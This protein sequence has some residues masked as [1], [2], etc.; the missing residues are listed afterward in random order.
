MKELN[1]HFDFRYPKGARIQADFTRPASEFSITALFGPSGCGKTTVLRCLAG[2]EHPQQGM[3]RFEGDIWFDRK[4]GIHRSPSERNVGLLFQ[5]YALFPHLTVKQNISYG[6][7]RK[8][9]DERRR[10]VHELLERFGLH[11]MDDRYPLQ[12]SGGQ[13]QRVAL[14]RTLAR[15]PRLL[16][17]DE[18]L[19]AL[20][21]MLRYQ[22]RTEL[23]QLLS[24]FAI[25]TFLVTHDWQEVMFLAD[26]LIVMN[27]GQILQCGPVQDVI[28]RPA[29]ESVARLV[30]MEALHKGH[31][32]HRSSTTT[33]VAVGRVQ[34]QSMPNSLIDDNVLVRIRAEDV[35]IELANRELAN[36]PNCIPATIRQIAADG[37]LSRLDLDCGF[38]L[39]AL[40]PRWALNSLKIEI[41]KEIYIHI[42]QEAVHLIP[43]LGPEPADPRTVNA[44]SLQLNHWS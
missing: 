35:E 20:D 24:D 16:L 26:H 39:S 17:L 40:L 37:G 3:I 32:I 18:P 34:L 10:V 9:A 36:L 22:M 14:A 6:L 4:R 44:S 15:Q 21:S 5:D 19:S 41:G 30:G 42:A 23:H 28:C 25:P 1:A 11:G 43:L 27:E 29:N 12:L 13:Q 33:T 7:R 38:A 31:I 8:T 2:L